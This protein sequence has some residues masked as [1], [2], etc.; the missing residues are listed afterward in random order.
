[1][2]QNG[3]VQAIVPFL[4]HN[5]YEVANSAVLTVGNIAADS[6]TACNLCL[7]HG[8]ADH[9]LTLLQKGEAI[10]R[11][12]NAPII[13][14][15]TWMILVLTRNCDKQ[16]T[17]HAEMLLNAVDRVISSSRESQ[18]MFVFSSLT[19]QCISDCLASLANILNFGSQWI[20]KFLKMH[21]F[22]E[23]VRSELTLVS[24]NDRFIS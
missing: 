7:Q 14:D 13:H 18:V 10:L 24:Q 16:D 23:V 5:T 1:M 21:I 11:T 4:K 19:T 17:V 9:I 6:E 15:I 8:V 3:A 22:G 2:I 20:D 12:R